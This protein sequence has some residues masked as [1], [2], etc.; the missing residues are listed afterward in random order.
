MPFLE[1]QR[2]TLED[3]FFLKEDQRL[4]EQL[5]T[6]RKMKESKESL[7]KTS[8]IAND[9][10]LQKLVELDIRP[11]TVATLALV[12]L[13]E[14][15]WADGK[16]DEKEKAAVLKAATGLFGKDSIDHQILQSWMTHRPPAHLLEA[17]THY[18]QGLCEKLSESEKNSLKG[19]LL[20][21]ARSV[22]EASGG[23]LGL[24]TISNAEKAMLKQLDTA[25]EKV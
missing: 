11:E 25:F 6:M 13:V 9:A 7:A 2:K 10:V 18:V 3:S 8:G 16:I 17:W 14:I 24:S 15:A 20:G 21:H 1:N 19:D 23:I 4:I 12:P 22:A 5:R